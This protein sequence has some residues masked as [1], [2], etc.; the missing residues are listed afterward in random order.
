MPRFK[1]VS[2]DIFEKPLD[3]VDA[4]SFV[5]MYREIFER[6]IYKFKADTDS[7][8]IIDC[9]ANVGVSTLYF[10]KTF[11]GMPHYSL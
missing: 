2:T 3:I 7:P 9:G 1:A 10:K 11:P 4:A 5:Y 6:Q 8:T